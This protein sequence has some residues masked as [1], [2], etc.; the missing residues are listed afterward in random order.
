M[1]MTKTDY[2]K[3]INY[4]EE[5]EAKRIEYEND[6]TNSELEEQYY[7][8]AQR[9]FDFIKNQEFRDQIRRAAALLEQGLF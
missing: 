9:L 4:Y 7:A 3:A 2:E 6:I 5:A 1:T 8:A